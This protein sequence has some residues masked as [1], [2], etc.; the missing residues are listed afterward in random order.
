MD[1]QPPVAGEAGTDLP[2]PAA[3]ARSSM[4]LDRRDWLILAGLLATFALVRVTLF[5]FAE[6]LYGDSVVRS[7]LA[8]RWANE[9]T[10][11][12][13]FKDGV[14]QFG[15]LHFYYMGLVMK[16][17]PSREHATRFASL[18]LGLLVVVPLYRLGKRLFSRRAG[19]IAAL[20]MSVWGLHVQASTTAASEAVF[21]FLFFLLLDLLFRGI[22]E[23]RFAPLAG[24]AVVANLLCALRYDGWMYVPLFGAAVALAGKDRLASVTRAVMFLGLCAPFPLWWMQMNEKATGDALYPI[25]YIDQY[26]AR[27]V[28]DG[29]AWLGG[30][31]QRAL[32]LFFWPGAVLV[33]TSLLVG[34][35]ALVGVV[36][37]LVRKERRALALLALI[38]VAYYAFRGAVLLDFSPLTRFFMAQIALALF[39]VDSG[40][41][42][43]CGTLP[44]GA[45]KAVAGLTA[46]LAVAT[47]AYLGWAT[48]W[49][50]GSPADTLRPISPL[51]TIPTDQ[52]A[53]ARH[54]KQVVKPGETVVIDEAPQ[55][56]DINVAFF[57]GLAEPR[58]AR[59]RWENFEKQLREQPHP[60]WMFIARGGTLETRDGIVPGAEELRWRDEVWR[61]DLETR[62]LFVYRLP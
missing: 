18:L 49:K 40:F 28:Q 56:M 10:L 5:P 41:T 2:S 45:R 48:A 52:M 7:E 59:R 14:Y 54:L 62:S 50:D 31:G 6:N 15:P 12:R 36:R 55:Y 11:Y 4:R 8:E 61:K 17:W 44:G 33:T 13:S 53:I 57:T 51:S 46:A 30:A 32:A 9:P 27:W 39:Y 38:P 25:H 24:A 60:R 21:L 42:A 23:E 29:V 22:E 26:H 19:V 35:F 43:V 3:S 58:L 47:P 34:F 16:A 37:S 20:G 1:Q